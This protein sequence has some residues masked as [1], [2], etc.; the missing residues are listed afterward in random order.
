MLCGRCGRRLGHVFAVA[1]DGLPQASPVR[2][3]TVGMQR[4]PTGTRRD[5]TTV[6][7][8]GAPA[9]VRYEIPC[10]RD[11]GARPQVTAHRLLKAFVVV[12]EQRRANIIIGGGQ[13]AAEK[14]GADL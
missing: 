7:E 2:G 10:H 9:K 3:N 13:C 14:G 6:M 8:P 5:I 12:G 1:G 4:P 11:C